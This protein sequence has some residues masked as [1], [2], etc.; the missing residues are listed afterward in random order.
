MYA[1]HERHPPTDVLRNFPSFASAGGPENGM[2][3]GCR[4]CDDEVGPNRVLIFLIL[5]WL[6]PV[7]R[8]S[9]FVARQGLDPLAPGS[10]GRIGR[11]YRQEPQIEHLGCVLPCRTKQGLND[12]VGD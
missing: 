11:T 12:R 10:N 6:T 8:I 4:G 9:L 2:K 1:A 7:R 5:P 3:A